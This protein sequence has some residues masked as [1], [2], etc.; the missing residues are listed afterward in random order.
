[1]NSRQPD[2]LFRQKLENLSTPAP[3][4]AWSRIEQG[5]RRKRSKFWLKLAAALLVL[6]VASFAIW[7]L[8]NDG[9][10]RDQIVADHVP[11]PAPPTP[12]TDSSSADPATSP[13]T[14]Q[15]DRQTHANDAPTNALKAKESPVAVPVPDTEQLAVLKRPDLEPERIEP[16]STDPLIS[17]TPDESHMDVNG[18]NQ[19]K[20]TSFKLV[21]TAEEVS[22]KYLNKNS[23]AGATVEKPKTSGLK[24]LLD[25]ASDLKNNQDPFGDLRHMKNE[26]F[27]LNF[28]G[29]KKHDQK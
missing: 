21:L 28:Q 7:S 18:P 27:A 29:D 23:V 4:A 12:L 14:D 16:V 13:D 2:H 6:F 25:K 26:L 24:K 5:L 20:G 22:A 10:R 9:S 3:G 11:A 19:D 17:E 1:M 8:R 15:A